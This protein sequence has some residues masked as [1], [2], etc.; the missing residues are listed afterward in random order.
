MSIEKSAHIFYLLIFEQ[1]ITFIIKLKNFDL[2]CLFLCLFLK[3][4]NE[5]NGF[6]YG[7]MISH[8]Y[9]SFCN[10]WVTRTYNGSTKL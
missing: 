9:R 7:K 1:I 2:N 3:S 10:T 8:G 5:L 4:S 6:S